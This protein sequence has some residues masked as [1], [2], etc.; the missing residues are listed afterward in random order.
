ML[1]GTAVVVLLV[2]AIV[3]KRRVCCSWGWGFV[4]RRLGGYIRHT[5]RRIVP[6]DVVSP[7]VVAAMAG[8][9]GPLGQDLD[10]GNRAGRAECLPVASGCRWTRSGLGRISTYTPFRRRPVRL[11]CTITSYFNVKM[12]N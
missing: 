4:D 11:Y 7:C 10:P 6:V 9:V 1:Q 8:L 12:L 2:T 3:H 5:S